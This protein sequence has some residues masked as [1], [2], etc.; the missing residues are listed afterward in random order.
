MIKFESLKED[1]QKILIKLEEVLNLEKTD[2][3]RD[4]AIQRFEIAVDLGWK[5]LKS[6]LEES[7]GIICKSPKGCLREAFSQEIIDYDDYWIKIVD[8]RNQTIHIYNEEFA[9]KIYNELPK[10][11]EYLKKLFEKTEIK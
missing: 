2:I 10:I 6:Y 4:S 5:T 11:L 3:N 1:F 9:N 8:F 7:K